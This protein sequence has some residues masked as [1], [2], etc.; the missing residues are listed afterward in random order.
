MAAT[1]LFCGAN[2]VARKTV[3]KKTVSKPAVNG[4][5]NGIQSP[6][7]LC[8]G[9]IEVAIVGG[10]CNGQTVYVDL[11][12]A[13]L[14]IERADR[15]HVDPNKPATDDSWFT[16]EYLRD[17]SKSFVESGVLP[18]CSSTMAAALRGKVLE[19]FNDLKKNTLGTVK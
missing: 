7:S 14:V 4:G 13:E 3:K 9:T 11:I 17:L 2:F 18:H 1:Q 12:E 5:V 15:K 16:V 10:P 6:T 19:A 8:D